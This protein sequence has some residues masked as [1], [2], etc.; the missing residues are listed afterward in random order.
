M[1]RKNIHKIRW[2]GHRVMTLND[3]V[4]EIIDDDDYGEDLFGDE[5]Q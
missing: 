2:M 4:F 1:E 5:I 3:K